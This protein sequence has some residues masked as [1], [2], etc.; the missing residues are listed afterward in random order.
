MSPLVLIAANFLREQ[1]WVLLLLLLWVMVNGAV[2][3]AAQEHPPEDLL[4]FVKLHAAYGVAL[5]A[6]FIAPALH[7][8]RRSRR[9]LG[10]LSKAVG[11]GEYLA[12]LLAGAVAAVA[13][14]TLF[15]ALAAGL[16][17]GLAG[18]PV[19]DVLA[20]LA[21][22]LVA[23]LLAA[24]VTLLFAVFLPPLFATAAA[25]LALLLPASLAHLMAAP[26]WLNVLPAYALVM[27]LMEWTT[28][29]DWR[30]AWQAMWLGLPQVA[31]LWL[32]ASRAFATR[33][34]AVAVE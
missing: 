27:N 23:A 7:N 20:V 30:P 34:I 31:L 6:F 14:Y 22:A 3:A 18:L 4:T 29:P 21:Q 33:D 26:A 17:F 24:T 10:V 15:I 5:G 8:E 16:L 2:F 32:A 19:L 28:G 9:I 1:R 25:V 11:R 12:G 13:L